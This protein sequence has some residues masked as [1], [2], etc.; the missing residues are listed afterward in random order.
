[1]AFGMSVAASTPFTGSNSKIVATF[2]VSTRGVFS[3]NLVTMPYAIGHRGD[4]QHW[5]ST[6]RGQDDAAD[7]GSAHV[8]AATE[9]RLDIHAARSYVN[10]LHV[11]TVF[12]NMPASCALQTAATVGPT[13]EYDSEEERRTHKARAS[14]PAKAA[15]S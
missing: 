1:M 8:K 5:S 11:D 12:L 4:C 9:Q 13:T 14:Q 3:V 6:R 7:P 10:E 15:F 2:R